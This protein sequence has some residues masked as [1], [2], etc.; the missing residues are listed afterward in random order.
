MQPAVLIVE[1]DPSI[2]ELLRAYLERAH[3]IPVIAATG[4]L[5]LTLFDAEVPAAV[6][7]DLNLPGTLDGLDVCRALREHSA[8]PIVML[9]ARDQELDRIFGLEIGA[10]DYVTKPFSPRELIARLNAILRRTQAIPPATAVVEVLGPITWDQQRRTTTLEGVQIPLTNREF[11]LLGFLITHR[12]IALSRRQLLDGVW[13]PEWYGDDR[14][15]DVHIRQLR[16][17][18]GESLPIATVWGVGYRLA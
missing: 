4:E 11:D 12:G 7:L 15:V 2:A 13:G 6:I 18:F 9:S 14:T 5:A 10:D 8:V 16:R 3:F 17:K 1:D